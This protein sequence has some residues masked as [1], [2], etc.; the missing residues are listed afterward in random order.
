M[1][2]LLSSGLC[3][4]TALEGDIISK[5]QIAKP[6][7]CEQ[8]LKTPVALLL[9]MGGKGEDQEFLAELYFFWFGLYMSYHCAEKSHSVDTNSHPTQPQ[10][11]L[12]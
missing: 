1:K 11:Y 8:E 12:P 4:S 5:F 9:Y 3:L 6:E 2:C 10:E 7:S